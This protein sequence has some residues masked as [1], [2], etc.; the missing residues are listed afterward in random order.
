MFL[1]PCLLIRRTSKGVIAIVTCCD[2]IP[3][4]AS[5]Q[6]LLDWFFSSYEGK[7]CTLTS[8][9]LDWFLGLEINW[10]AAAV[11]LIAF[12]KAFLNAFGTASVLTYLHLNE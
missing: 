2:G 4:I 6:Q 1:D 5:S 8:G 7:V 9:P 11:F 10:N 12:L 3:Q